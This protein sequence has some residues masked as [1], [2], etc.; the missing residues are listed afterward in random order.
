MSLISIVEEAVR[1]KLSDKLG[2]MFV[3]MSD[4]NI[5]FVALFCVYMYKKVCR[6]SMIICF[7]FLKEKDI[8]S[9]H[10][11]N[12]F[13]GGW[14]GMDNRSKKFFFLV[15]AN[16]FFIQQFAILCGAAPL[17]GCNNHKLNPAIE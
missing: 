15:D 4:A 12:L 2:I 6:E 13:A 17:L 8:S 5:H 7:L 10:P 3:K 16:F 14:R 11:L 9:Q 1:N